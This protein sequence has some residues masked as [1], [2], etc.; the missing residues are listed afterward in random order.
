[1]SI[2]AVTRAMVYTRLASRQAQQERTHLAH[3]QLVEDRRLAR[4]VKT[5]DEHPHLHTQARH[6]PSQGGWQ[7]RCC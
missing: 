2:V 7:P 3:L 1:M 4:I 5:K 6:M